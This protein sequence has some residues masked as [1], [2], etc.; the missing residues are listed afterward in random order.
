VSRRRSRGRWLGDRR[1]AD[2][3]NLSVTD[4]LPAVALLLLRVA[5]PRLPSVRLLSYPT[6]KE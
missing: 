1:G 3:H 2:E 6:T 5:D 4:G